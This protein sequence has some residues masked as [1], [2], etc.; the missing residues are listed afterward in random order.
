MGWCNESIKQEVVM[1]T[2][3]LMNRGLLRAHAVSSYCERF[4]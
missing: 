4:L 3:V 1:N 2:A